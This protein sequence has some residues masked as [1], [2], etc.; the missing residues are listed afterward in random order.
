MSSFISIVHSFSGLDLTA[1]AIS[2]LHFGIGKAK[3]YGK[4]PIMFRTK[5]KN[6]EVQ[7]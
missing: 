2:F 5:G 1:Q 3:S 4:Q 6:G 7:S